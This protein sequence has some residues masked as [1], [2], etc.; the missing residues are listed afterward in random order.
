MFVGYPCALNPPI[1][2]TKSPTAVALTSVLGVGI[3][4]PLVQNDLV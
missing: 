2:Y 3:G 1:T 4:D